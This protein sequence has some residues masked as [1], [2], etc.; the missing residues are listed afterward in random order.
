MNTKPYEAQA[1]AAA[2]IMSDISNFD[3]QASK[4]IDG[5]TINM[6]AEVIGKNYP[7]IDLNAIED[8]VTNYLRRFMID[9]Y[10]SASAM[11]S[12]ATANSENI[13]ATAKLVAD[14]LEKLKYIDEDNPSIQILQKNLGQNFWKKYSSSQEL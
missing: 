14:V 10:I 11:L 2:L 6:F 8:I 1:A 7:D 5:E 9:Y 12:I 4:L 3:K 13:E